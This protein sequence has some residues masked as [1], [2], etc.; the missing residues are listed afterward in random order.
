MKNIYILKGDEEY[1]IQKWIAD[2]KTKFSPE[3]IDRLD[4]ET[5]LEEIIEKLSLTSLFSSRRLVLLHEVDI[6]KDELLPLLKNTSEDITV[7]FINPEG[8]NF[9]H[10]KFGFIKEKGEV[11][12]FNKLRS[13]ENDK[14]I[15]WITEQFSKEDKEISPENAEKIFEAV[16]CDLMALSSEIE[17]IILFAGDK[18]TIDERDIFEVVVDGREEVFKLV[19]ALREKKAGEAIGLLTEFL[20]DNHS[21]F[22]LIQLVAGQFL[23]LLSIKCLKEEGKNPYEISKTL[24]INFYFTKRLFFNADQ[25]SSDEIV[26]FL[27][28]LHDV[29]VKLKTGYDPSFWLSLAIDRICHGQKTN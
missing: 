29:D 23:K 27:C 12:E 20:Q 26:D 9:R 21:P 4:K 16:G 2:F 14:A 19:D 24:K 1:L 18:K 8:L 17:K 15:D 28:F 7:V 3:V 22:A 11:F 10:K 5:S 13:W 6:S 25:F